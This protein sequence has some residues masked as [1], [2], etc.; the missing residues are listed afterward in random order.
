MIEASLATAADW[1]GGALRRGE[2]DARFRGLSTDTRTLEAGNLFVALTGPQFDGHA[3]T[4]AAAERGAAGAVVERAQDGEVAQIAVDDG[5]R[6]LGALGAA[7]R[8]RF[9]G[10]VIAITGSNGKTTVKECVAAILRQA[11]PAMATR[12]NLNNDVG[13]PLMLAELDA[14]HWAGVLELASNTPGEIDWL[15]RLTAPTVGLVTNTEAAHLAGFATLE[16]VADANGEL[17]ERLADD[18]VAVINADDPWAQRWRD[19][20]GSRRVITFASEAAADVRVPLDSADP[21]L[22]IGGERRPFQWALPGA[23]NRRNAAAAAGAAWALGLEPGLIVAGLEAAAPVAGR[24]VQCSGVG[25]SLVLDDSYNANP[26][27]F[28]AAL[29]VLEEHPGRRWA[30][31]GEMAELGEGSLE[32]HR[33]LGACARSAGVEHL[34]A[35]GPHAE[36]IC[37]GFGAGAEVATDRS[38]LARTLAEALDRDVAVLIK[39][40]R[41]NRLEQVVAAISATPPPDGEASCC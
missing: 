24:L 39:G 16:G 20:A 1:A 8:G 10:P 9:A 23:H 4:D 3:F 13:L 41:S 15:T 12:G 37:A 11:G 5:R 25:G 32:A 31:V 28:A 17:Y 6:A 22:E 7:W 18:A 30:V 2:P 29:A 35:L 27:S 26:G 14:A 34:W 40:S 33:A 38:V 21:H 36:Q 19:L